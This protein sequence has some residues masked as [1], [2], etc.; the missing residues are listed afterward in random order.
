K[1]MV[2]AE[3]EERDRPLDDLAVPP[4]DVARTLGRK[5]GPEL[6]VAVVARGRVEHGPEK[7]LRRLLRPGRS[8]IH[9]E[10]SEDL[11]EVAL[12]ARPVLRRDRALSVRLPSCRRLQ[13]AREQPLHSRADESLHARTAG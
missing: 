3:R 7:S 6:R 12:V 11:T 4:V 2:L 1:R 9:A 5:C 13:D 10:R 8:E